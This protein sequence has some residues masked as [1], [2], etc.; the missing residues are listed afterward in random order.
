MI[1][2]H[3]YDPWRFETASCQ[4]GVTNCD[5]G[6]VVSLLGTTLYLHLCQQ[7]R[8][9]QESQGI[10]EEMWFS[11]REQRLYLQGQLSAEQEQCQ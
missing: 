5:L 9:R 2:V 10:T 11:C 7:L 1:V 6:T 3:E 4:A 8:A